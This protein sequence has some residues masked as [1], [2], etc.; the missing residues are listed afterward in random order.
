MSSQSWVYQKKVPSPNALKPTLHLVS[1]DDDFIS[2]EESLCKYI[3]DF[4]EYEKK[5]CVSMSMEETSNSLSFWNTPNA[6]TL[7]EVSPLLRRCTYQL[8][9]LTPG[10]RKKMKLKIVFK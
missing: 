6:K 5:A 3:Q 2:G 1:A 7:N 10:K 9:S 8:S 4:E